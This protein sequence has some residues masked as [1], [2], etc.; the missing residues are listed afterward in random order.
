[1]NYV[2]N[3]NRY[4]AT[5][6]KS[7]IASSVHIP[8]DLKEVF[9][10]VDA[11]ID[12]LDIPKPIIYKI[13]PEKSEKESKSK[14]SKDTKEKDSKKPET[15]VKSSSQKSEEKTKES[16]GSKSSETETKKP[17][18]EG[19]SVESSKEEKKDSIDV[20]SAPSTQE[21]SV[22]VKEEPT[23]ELEKP[24]D[25]QVTEI[26]TQPKAETNSLSEQH[27]ENEPKDMDIDEEES[28]N[29]NGPSIIE[30]NVPLEAIA[31][32][33]T[34]V[35]TKPTEHVGKNNK[36]NVKVLLISLPTL[37]DIYEK[38]FG[39]DFDSNNSRYLFLSMI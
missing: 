21:S 18:V 19:K 4:S 39:P 26:V 10:N 12:L 38:I 14:D 31:S 23:E 29:A 20:T 37:S 2:F 8:S 16:P 36:F 27:D 1:M 25:S 13:Q 34:R 15:P 3:R 32:K 17:A 5:E 30:T 9:Y 7:R 35:E 22:S 11:D 28:S 6:L 33:S 24:I